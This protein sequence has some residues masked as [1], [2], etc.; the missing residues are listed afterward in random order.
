[1]KKKQKNQGNDLGTASI[2]EWYF[3]QFTSKKRLKM[4]IILIVIRKL[5][6]CME[7]N[8]ACNLFMWN[9]FAMKLL[10]ENLYKSA[11]QGVYT[12]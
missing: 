7:Y 11:S 12:C 10:R 4:I 9:V 3:I 1:M 5:P 8:T 6:I 2:C